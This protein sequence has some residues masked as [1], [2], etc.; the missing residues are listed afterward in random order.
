M[1][2]S[3]ETSTINIDEQASVTLSCVVVANRN[4]TIEWT[5]NV[6]SGVVLASGIGLSLSLTQNTADLAH[7]EELIC[8]ATLDSTMS[9]TA[10][11]TTYSESLGIYRDEQRKA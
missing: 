2:V 8:S 11:V 9:D 7:Q 1:T 3:P 4:A 10:S 6:W 5:S